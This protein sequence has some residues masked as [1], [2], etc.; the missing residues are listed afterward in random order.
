MS[1]CISLAGC[2]EPKKEIDPRLDPPLV[3]VTKLGRHNDTLT[4]YTGTVK[5]RVESNISFRVGGKITQRLVDVGQPIKRGQALFRLDPTDL[6]HAVTAK[7]E[8]VESQINSVESKQGNLE[9]ARARLVQAESDEQR[10]KNAAAVGVVTDQAYD[11]YKAAAESARAYFK[12]AQADVKAATDQASAL[13]A[14]K[15]VA[16]N[17]SD[18]S[19]LFSDADGVV[20]DI[21]A[22]PG[23]VVAVGQS[24]AKIAH[25]GPR[26]AS[27]S[28]PETVRPPIG[29]TVEAQVYD[30]KI[31]VCKARL[32]QLSQAADPLTRTFE[33]RYVLS[34]QAAN[35]PLGSTVAIAIESSRPQKL[36]ATVP[37]T[38]LVDK[39]RGTG[40]WTVDLGSS[41]VHFRAVTVSVLGN[42]DAV[43]VDGLKPGEM[44]VSQGAHLLHENE[45]VRIAIAGNN[46]T[47]ATVKLS[48]KETE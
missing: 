31:P 43:I 4:S 1:L 34:G 26:E 30:T 48:S 11:Q 40:V 12:A 33:A 20:T 19:T 25:C 28:L 3:P 8:S 24:V 38:A 42:E 13:M 15:K 7:E 36:E 47:E 22:E 27:I 17:E 21:M 18:Y 29:Q 39:G 2:S 16:Q 5:A 45:K 9:A 35:A 6:S 10:Y 41:V 44:F 37:L 46:D 32:R 14:Q 23:Q